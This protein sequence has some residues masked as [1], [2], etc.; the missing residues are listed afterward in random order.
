VPSPPLPQL[1]AAGQSASPGGTAPTSRRHVPVT[2]LDTRAGLI[3]IIA[4]AVLLR[5]LAALALGN[6]VEPISGAYDQVSYDALAQ[7]LLSGHGFS[8]PTAW[9]P[10]TAANEATAHWSYLYTVYLAAVYAIFGHAPLVAR[11]LQVAVAALQVWLAYL[12]GRRLFGESVGLVAAALT[13]CYAYFIFFNAALMTQS[14][15]IVA[16]LGALNLALALADNPSTGKWLALGLTLGAGALLRQTM[17]LFSP[18][19][20]LWVIWAAGARRGLEAGPRTSRDEGVRLIE[21][22]R[23]TWRGAAGAV[24]MIAVMILP[25]T[26]YN[27]TAFHDF[28]ILNTNGGYFFWAANHPSRG[29]HFDGNY[30]P[31]LPTDLQALG[32]PAIDRVLYSEGLKFILN[33]PKRFLLLALDRTKGYFW[34]L[35]SEKSSSLG[36]LGRLMSFTLYLPFMLAGLW[37]SFKHWR[38]C[39][40]L[41][42]YLAFDTVLHLSSWAAPRYRLPS[43]ALLIIFAALA[44]VRLGQCLLDRTGLTFRSRV[45]A[46][47]L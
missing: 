43:D 40:P 14:F 4:F 29:T 21:R 17:L 47:G 45:P 38:T 7:R 25:W 33:D 16:V 20:L 36:N 18:V 39:L 19:L 44:V 9:Y 46:G 15:Y 27:Y 30:A 10:F 28:L 26:I 42:L 2:R 35:P 6:R 23:R 32:E 3:L 31:R 12:L 24:V 41:Y 34:L 37:L 5:I 22:L 11:L 8:F 1:S 13:A